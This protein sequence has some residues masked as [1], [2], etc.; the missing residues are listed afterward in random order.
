M[1][2][3]MPSKPDIPRAELFAERLKALCKKR[4]RLNPRLIKDNG[5][6]NQNFLAEDILNKLD[7]VLTQTS[8]GRILMKGGKNKKGVANPSR[9]TLE[10]LERYFGEKVFPD[11]KADPWP[12]ETVTP[13]EWETLQDPVREYIEH[14]VRQELGPIRPEKNQPASVRHRLKM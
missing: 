5:E 7:R 11:E 8:I 3:C 13:E 12:F 4:A 9:Y 10:T 2:Y 1:H 6:V 14:K